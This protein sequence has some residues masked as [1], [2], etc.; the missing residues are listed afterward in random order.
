MAAGWVQA[1]STAELGTTGRDRDHTIGSVV[2]LGALW[3]CLFFGVLVLGALI[4]STAL[5]GFARFDGELVTNY[6]S[7]L[8]PETT[9]FRAGILGTVWVM[10]ATAWRFLLRLMTLRT[11]C[12]EKRWWSAKRLAYTRS[13]PSLIRLCSKL[14]G[15]AIPLSEATRWPLRK[16][17]SNRSPVKRSSK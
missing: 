1:T 6:S 7:R 17:S 2:F 9:G 3:F 10:I 11:S 16:S 5:D 13:D 15:W 12:C 8:R 14:S 4:A